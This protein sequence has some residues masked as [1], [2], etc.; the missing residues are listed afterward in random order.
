MPKVKQIRVSVENRPGTLA[1]V[2]KLLGDNKIDIRA[3]LAGP[4]GSQG[5]VDLLVDDADRAKKLLEQQG[6]SCN[7]QEVLLVELP[8]VPG[9]LGKLAGKL[10]AKGI[11]VGYG[12]AVALKGTRKAGVVLAVSD[13]DKAA[14]IR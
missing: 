9:A 2:A 1:Q 12:Y 13:L 11:N 3:F 14:R 8:N 6:L 5:Y 4:G 7:E 10:A